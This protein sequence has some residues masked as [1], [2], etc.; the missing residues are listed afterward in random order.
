VSWE[1][2]APPMRAGASS[3]SRGCS[4]LPATRGVESDI[5]AGHLS[6][7]PRRVQTPIPAPPARRAREQLFYG[8]HRLGSHLT[9]PRARPTRRRVRVG[10][11]H[12]GPIPRGFG[13][14]LPADLTETSVRQQTV[15]SPPDSSRKPSR[16]VLHDLLNIPTLHRN[17]LM[18]V[19][20]VGGELVGGIPTQVRHPGVQPG[21]AGHCLGAPPRPLLTA[22]EGTLRRSEPVERRLQMPRMLDLLAGGEGGKKPHTEVDTD[23]AAGTLTLRRA[24]AHLAHQL[25]GE[26]DLPAAIRA[27]GNGAP[28]QPRSR[29]TAVALAGRARLRRVFARHLTGGLAGRARGVALSDTAQKLA[30]GLV[31]LDHADLRQLDVVGVH[32]FQLRTVDLERLP[33]A[34]LFLKPGAPHPAASEPP[35]TG[36]EEPFPRDC[37][38]PKRRLVGASKVAG[39]PRHTDRDLTGLPV[40]PLRSV[41]PLGPHAAQVETPRDFRGRR[42]TGGL[43][44]LAGIQ[45]LSDLLD[46]PVVG[47]P[48][49]PSMGGE[50]ALLP[51]GCIQRKHERLLDEPVLD[52]HRGSP[53]SRC[54]YWDS[55]WCF[56]Q[57][58]IQANRIK[59]PPKG[60]AIIDP[61]SVWRHTPRAG[62]WCAVHHP[63]FFFS[64]TLSALT[65]PYR[66]RFAQ[67]E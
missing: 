2:P 50:R 62:W 5:A 43:L 46:P 30:R 20:E 56:L 36:V 48:G 64:S 23:R 54:V 44:R 19:D 65:A 17:P 53:P 24:S 51:R 31:C 11:H 41:L 59:P 1:P 52:W 9:A 63:P 57:Q 7:D 13:L 61:P 32:H 4:R 26:R 10:H 60:G 22:G 55:T 38:I 33:A 42:L 67:R 28:H 16:P 15:P 47:E 45:R 12:G 21:D 14:Q 37:R 49:A 35:G 40:D 6:E 58:A 39:Y 3:P 29:H 27:A 25:D 34:A 18:R 8:R 66:C